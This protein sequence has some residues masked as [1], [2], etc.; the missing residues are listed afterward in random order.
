MQAMLRAKCRKHKQ[1]FAK[2]ADMY[3]FE[4]FQE[5]VSN[6]E[7][8][9]LG[10]FT[11]LQA[12]THVEMKEA[13][14]YSERFPLMVGR[15]YHTVVPAPKIPFM[16]LLHVERDLPVDQTVARYYQKMCNDFLTS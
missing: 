7:F 9:E 15:L 12:K 13:V 11:F 14:V 16:W 8:H 6:E 5:T 3:N 2:T 10:R 1:E 4:G